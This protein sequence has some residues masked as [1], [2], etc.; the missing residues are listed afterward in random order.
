M[1]QQTD[2]PSS[3]LDAAL[4]LSSTLGPVFRLVPL[5][6]R[7][8]ETNGHLQATCDEQEIRA[9]WA[10]T[11]DANI[12]I[13]LGH[14]SPLVPPG[15]VLVC[16]DVDVD[17]NGDH[18]LGELEAK[19]G[20]IPFGPRV[21]S[22]S[23]GFHCYL[24]APPGTTRNILGPGLDLRAFGQYMAAPPS[25]APPHQPPGAPPRPYFWEASAGLDDCPIPEAPAWMLQP[26]TQEDAGGVAAAEDAAWSYLGAAF[27][28]AGMLGK[29]LRDG[30]RA[31]VCPWK[32]EHSSGKDY[33]T[34]TI[35][36]APRGGSTY[37]AFF[38]SHAHCDGRRAEDALAA[39]PPSAVN[40]ARLRYPIPDRAPAVTAAD[41]PPAPE[42]PAKR[43][44]DLW[45]AADMAGDPPVPDYL[46]PKLHLAGSGRAFGLTAYSGA[47]KTFLCADIAIAIAGGFPYC[48][49]DLPV[50][51]HGRVVHLDLEM[52][53]V[54]L[55]RRYKRLAYGR[56]G[57]DVADLG[58]NLLWRSSPNFRLTQP[59][60]EVLL[61]RACDGAVLCILDSLK[62]LSPGVD[63]NDS[64]FAEGL[65]KLARVSEQTACAFIVI[66]HEGKPSADGQ[67]EA[68]YRGRGTSAIQ[69]W[70]S[71][72]WSVRKEKDHW[73]IDH[74]KSELGEEERDPVCVR[75]V[76]IGERDT[77]D[78][79]SPGIAFVT[80]DKPE[81]PD[82]KREKQEAMSELMH[83]IL[84]ELGREPCASY[85]DM[86]TRIGIRAAELKDPWNALKASGMLETC[87]H[88]G[89]RCYRPKSDS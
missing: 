21:L 40:A 86:G 31:V 39:L 78:A 66:H 88:D 68:R 4:Y 51:K 81:K 2:P 83:R 42:D 15:K 69:G 50:K 85:N 36:F 5:Q 47:G 54:N 74:G 26:V 34:S 41:P 37:G 52:G 58:E 7:P 10:R 79:P 59:D 14:P 1:I 75:L 23:G 73:E 57:F 62:V 70:L 89:K 11:P 53:R 77:P 76:D 13:A 87:S 18:T 44:L 22:P 12:G 17:A 27:E 46:V 82:K 80:Y 48:W 61:K 28:A 3:I 63:E 38:C 9:R 55:W 33:D 24:Y 25:W 72:Q 35:L 65:E 56:G 20:P 30:R 32:H 45:S 16:L 64:R 49:G 6:K 43:P 67:R 8:I 71:S 60:A 84:L 29:R 19:H